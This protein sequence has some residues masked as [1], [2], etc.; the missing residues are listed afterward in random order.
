MSTETQYETFTFP[1]P[2]GIVGRMSVPFPM[3]DAQFR[4]LSAAVLLF[5]P[6]RL[7]EV[8]PVGTPAVDVQPVDMATPR[9]PNIVKE[10]AGRKGGLTTAKA[11]AKARVAARAG[12]LG[13][14][15]ARRTC[16]KCGQEKG[17]TGFS[18]GHLTCRQCEVTGKGAVTEASEAAHRAAEE[19]SER[20]R[21]IACGV[22]K[23]LAAFDE[24]ALKCKS[25]ASLSVKRFGAGV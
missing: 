9:V 17:V 15:G 11:K 7:S 23:A 12:V 24:G 8:A 4:S 2:G 14:G 5:Q 1:L 19:A 25:C 13:K 21:C 22:S 16:T 10:Q 18:R 6:A 20:K 3:T